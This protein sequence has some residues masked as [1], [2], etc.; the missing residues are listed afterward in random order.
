MKLVL[1]DSAHCCAKMKSGRSFVT[2]KADCSVT[3]Q[4][5]QKSVSF[6]YLP[7]GHGYDFYYIHGPT[8]YWKKPKL[9]I[10]GVLDVSLNNG[11]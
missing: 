1:D 2:V 10:F 5:Q 7:L 8:Q 4:K 3:H 6:F 9:M 11:P